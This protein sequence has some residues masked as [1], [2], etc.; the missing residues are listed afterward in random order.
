ME[1]PKSTRRG[2]GL[3]RTPQDM[4]KA[5]ECEQLDL[6]DFVAHLLNQLA[7]AGTRNWLLGGYSLG[8]RIVGE[9]ALCT[10]FLGAGVPETNE[11][12]ELLNERAEDIYRCLARAEAG[13]PLT[14]DDLS[15]LIL[16]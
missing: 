13:H 8:D 5:E 16:A 11:V 10:G 7:R 14:S 4:D 9:V 1:C 3:H 15:F 2:R 6:P 12:V